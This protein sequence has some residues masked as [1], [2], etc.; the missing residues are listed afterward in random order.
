M[1]SQGWRLATFTNPSWFLYV[2]YQKSIDALD[3]MI[4][5]LYNN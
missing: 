4:N 2:N 5:E 3:R 1:L